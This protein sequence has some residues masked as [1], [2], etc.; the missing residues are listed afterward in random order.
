MIHLDLLGKLLG[1]AYRRVRPT[2]AGRT[3]S[4]RANPSNLLRYALYKGLFPYV[5]GL[6]LRARAASCSGSL[7]LGKGTTVR[8]PK[9]LHLGAGCSIGAFSQIDCL[10]TKGVWLGDRVTLREFCWIQVSSSPFDLGAQLSV[11][12]DTY[13]GPNAVL[14]AGA[15]VRIGSGCQIGAGFMLSAE[16]HEI[17]I[18][19]TLLGGDVTK[20]GIEIGD[21]CWIGNRV[22]ILDGVTVGD[23]A[24][25]GAGAVVT[26]DIPTMAVAVGVPARVIRRR[27]EVSGDIT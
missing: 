1:A 13:I 19:E 2:G 18:A 17:D 12:K 8:F 27:R 21:G 9:L 10:S 11:A 4:N 16:E 14:G 26:K 6:R 20:R 23:G 15:P 22:T 24:V 25:I 3:G 7:F 5:R